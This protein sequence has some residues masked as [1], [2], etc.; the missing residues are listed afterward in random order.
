MINK[1]NA[2]LCCSCNYSEDNKYFKLYEHERRKNS[3]FYK[4]NLGLWKD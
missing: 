1:R 2:V 4:N 3:N